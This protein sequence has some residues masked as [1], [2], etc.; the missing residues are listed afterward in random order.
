MSHAEGLQ[1]SWIRRTLAAGQT[2]TLQTHLRAAGYTGAVVSNVA[3]AMSVGIINHTNGARTPLQV[4]LSG[5]N[6]TMVKTNSGTNISLPS[7]PYAMHAQQATL[8]ADLRAAGQSG[9]VVMLYGDE[10]TIFLPDRPAAS[11]A[12]RANS[13]TI[14]PDDPYP[15]WDMFGAYLG[16]QSAATILGTSGNV[17]SAGGTPQA[18]ALKQFARLKITSGTR[19]NHL[20]P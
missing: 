18:E 1:P 9:A 17:R 2:A 8:Q 4:V 11:P 13:V 12:Q 10:W 6:V 15:A 7:Y 5:T 3:A 19:Y 14:T 20:M 16:N